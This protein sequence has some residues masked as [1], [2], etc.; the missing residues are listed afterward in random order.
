MLNHKDQVSSGSDLLLASGGTS[1]WT[2][3]GKPS[4]STVYPVFTGTARSQDY[5]LVIRST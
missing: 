3:D 4:G 5:T 1:T 2:S